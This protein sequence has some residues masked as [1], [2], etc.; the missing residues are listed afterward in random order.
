MTQTGTI[1]VVFKLMDQGLSSGEIG[2][3]MSK[4]VGVD[5]REVPVSTWLTRLKAE[6]YV[7]ENETQLD[8]DDLEALIKGC[9]KLNIL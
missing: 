1:A 5:W 6:G 8:V 4:I 7:S 3:A 9:L 2:R